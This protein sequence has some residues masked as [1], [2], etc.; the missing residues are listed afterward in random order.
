MTGP[1]DDPR[2]LFRDEDL[3]KALVAAGKKKLASEVEKH[4]PDDV[5]KKLGDAS[6]LLDKLK[7]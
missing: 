4:I 3:Q 6:G 1:L 7:R 2:V 5:K